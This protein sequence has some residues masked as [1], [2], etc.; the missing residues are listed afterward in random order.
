MSQLRWRNQNY[1]RLYQCADIHVFRISNRHTKRKQSNWENKVLYCNA[2]SIW[3]GG[4]KLVLRCAAKQCIQCATR[5]KGRQWS[6]RLGLPRL[7]HSDSR[8]YPLARVEERLSQTRPCVGYRLPRGCSSRSDWNDTFLHNSYFSNGQRCCFCI[9]RTNAVV[10]IT[11]RLS[12]RN[13]MIKRQKRRIHL[14]FSLCWR[15]Y[16]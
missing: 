6:R 1:F 15:L 11:K 9:C 13:Y 8:I 10:A 2:Q 14:R 7:F 4:R 3:Q 5:A 12:V 16:R